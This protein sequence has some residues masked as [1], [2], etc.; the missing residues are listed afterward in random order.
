MNFLS[1]WN[2]KPSGYISEAEER[3]QAYS[4]RYN[5]HTTA[6]AYA[7]YAALYIDGIQGDDATRGGNPNYIWRDY[8]VGREERKFYEQAGVN[9]SPVVEWSPSMA[10]L[11][12]GIHQSIVELWQQIAETQSSGG[13]GGPEYG[14]AGDIAYI[15][16]RSE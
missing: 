6:Q 2:W 7:Y 1:L 12:A 5:I 9:E 4:V 11:T 14:T 10:Q 16:G 15:P 8:I 13:W 3:S